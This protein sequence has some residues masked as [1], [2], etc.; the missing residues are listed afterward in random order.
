MDPS[1]AT[2]RKSTRSQANGDC[3]EVADLDD[4]VAIRD[5]KDTTGPVLVFSR[6]AFTSFVA[7][8]KT[9]NPAR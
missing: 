5:S 1:R 7:G 2:W 8:I 6:E 3:V 4:A 9:D